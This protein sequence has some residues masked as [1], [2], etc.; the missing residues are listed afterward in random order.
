MTICNDRVERV[1]QFLGEDLHSLKEVGIQVGELSSFSYNILLRA[2]SLAKGAY[3]RLQWG[4][5]HA[6]RKQESIQ[7]HFDVLSQLLKNNLDL[8]ERDIVSALHHFE[9]QI[10]KT[11]HLQG[12]EKARKKGLKEIAQAEAYSVTFHGKRNSTVIELSE[13]ARYEV[14]VKDCDCQWVDEQ[15]KDLEE[16][17]WFQAMPA[18]EKAFLSAAVAEDLE[19]YTMKTPTTGARPG[20]SNF[21]KDTLTIPCAGHG[22]QRASFY[23]HSTLSKRSEEEAVAV[24]HDYFDNYKDEMIED[25][26][27]R[28]PRYTYDENEVITIPILMESLLTPAFYEVGNKGSD[29]NTRMLRFK[30]AAIRALRDPNAPSVNKDGVTYEFKIISNNQPLNGRRS[31]VLGADRKRLEVGHEIVRQSLAAIINYDTA[32]TED[33]LQLFGTLLRSFPEGDSSILKEIDID[34]LCPKEPGKKYGLYIETLRAYTHAWSRG[35]LSPDKENFPLFLASCEAIL[36]QEAG[37]VVELNCKS[38]K[39]RVGLSKSHNAFMRLHYAKTG[40][41]PSYGSQFANKAEYDLFTQCVTTI[42]AV[43]ASNVAP[44]CA[45]MKDE[46]FLS[47]AMTPSFATQSEAFKSNKKLASQN[48]VKSM[49][50]KKSSPIRKEMERI[51]Q[52]RPVRLE[53]VKEAVTTAKE[54]V[55]SYLA[56]PGASERLTQ[57]LFGDEMKLDLRESLYHEIFELKREKSEVR[58]IKTKILGRTLIRDA[59]GMSLQHVNEDQL[60]AYNFGQLALTYAIAAETIF[61]VKQLGDAHERLAFQEAVKAASLAFKDRIKEFKTV[62][63]QEKE[64]DSFVLQVLSPLVIQASNGMLSLAQVKKSLDNTKNWVA[65][66]QPTAAVATIDSIKTKAG[67]VDIVRTEEPLTGLTEALRKEY[68]DRAQKDWYLCQSKEERGLIEHFMPYILQGHQIPSQLR[69]NL[70]G[71]KNAYRSTTSLCA[72][73]SGLQELSYSNHC[74]AIVPVIMPNHKALDQLKQSSP[75]VEL[76]QEQ[77]EERERRMR[78]ERVR[79]TQLGLDQ[80]RELTGAESNTMV[81]LNSRLGDEMI[82]RRERYWKEEDKTE[83]LDKEMVV[84]TQEAAAGLPKSYGAKVCLNLM[85]LTERNEVDSIRAFRTKTFDFMA[86]LDRETNFAEGSKEAELVQAMHDSF[87]RLGKHLKS[88]PLKRFFNWLDSESI[89]VVTVQEFTLL[90]GL[91][92]QLLETPG[93]SEEFR[94]RF[95]RHEVFYACASGENRTGIVEITAQIEAIAK[96]LPALTGHKVKNLKSL[97]K[98]LAN[99]G[100]LQYITG[101]QGGIMGAESIRDKSMGSLPAK[102]QP[103]S[104]VISKR[105]AG[106][107]AASKKLLQKITSGKKS[108]VVEQAKM[109]DVSL[110]L[111]SRMPAHEEHDEVMRD[112]TAIK[113]CLAQWKRG[114]Q[115]PP[116]DSL[117]RRCDKMLAPGL[118]AEDAKFNQ[119]HLVAALCKLCF[120]RVITASENGQAIPTHISELLTILSDMTGNPEFKTVANFSQKDLQELNSRL[121]EFNLKKK[122]TITGA[123]VGAVAMGLAVF[124]VP[125]LGAF[126]VNL[127]AVKVLA[128]FGLKAKIGLDAAAA[129]GGALT[130]ARKVSD[131]RRSSARET[132]GTLFN[133]RRQTGNYV[134]TRMKDVAKKRKGLAPVLNRFKNLFGFTKE[135]DIYVNRLLSEESDSS[136]SAMTVD[137]GIGTGK[138]DLENHFVVVADLNKST[139]PKQRFSSGSEGLAE[140]SNTNNITLAFKRDDLREIRVEK[141]GHHSPAEKVVDLLHE[142]GKTEITLTGTLSEKFVE[143]VQL[144]ANSYGMQVIDKRDN[145]PRSYSPTSVIGGVSDLDEAERPRAMSV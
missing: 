128:A 65:L 68:Q 100:H 53:E 51:S 40:E 75:G 6:E 50:L 52:T 42:P 56:N 60:G 96:R 143:I 87:E 58:G 131:S 12:S 27:A 97:Y 106:Y 71:L 46:P 121:K 4:V 54:A 125:V 45:G 137:A 30:E 139:L 90:S 20:G 86:Q 31:H 48:K 24:L 117:I 95:Q 37:G 32:L 36:M 102:Y 133:A 130:G 63:E 41:M 123:C 110:T 10:V 138:D 17:R 98:T 1:I 9:Y 28:Y 72:E 25:F 13:D 64:L 145:R 67:A 22:N 49:E 120:T 7:S 61:D 59:R 14:M 89:G 124:A 26:K 115:H 47:D 73:G 66:Y 11:L 142:Q 114:K 113:K 129:T 18:W 107:K 101:S 76:A 122:K 103:I 19:F 144:R 88:T 55:E 2:R 104:H 21:G 112:V 109:S 81:A 105:Y 33:K 80:Q 132:R 34:A 136:P 108:A 85:R 126:A 15:Y 38:S 35:P 29:N 39:D 93:L 119:E 111:G 79:L 94:Q 141:S 83:L 134:L 57:S 23:Y 91:Y 77:R 78:V 70:P 62:E 16:K 118:T 84:A 135:S 74:A 82:E 116:L 92:N 44:G 127:A 140:I 99:S 3:L 43:I 8:S 5:E 69:R